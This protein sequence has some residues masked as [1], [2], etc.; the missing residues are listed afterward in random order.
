MEEQR[1]LGG[2]RRKGVGAMSDKLLMIFVSKSLSRWVGQRK[3][4]YRETEIITYVHKFSCLH[5]HSHV[6]MLFRHADP[7]HLKLRCQSSVCFLA[8][9]H[10]P[11]VHLQRQLPNK[12]ANGV[13]DREISS[14][15][16]YTKDPP[17][18]ITDTSFSSYLQAS[19]I[20]LG[21]ERQCLSTAS[22][23]LPCKHFC[24]HGC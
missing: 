8:L 23:V 21:K 17:H 7:S 15:D 14:S 4:V 1:G 10:C 18:A 6:T 12:R 3:V 5:V 24:F 16:S 22:H 11:F 20:Y 2:G 13:C 9:T 19:C